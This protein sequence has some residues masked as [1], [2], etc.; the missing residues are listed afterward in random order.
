VNNRNCTNYIIVR[1]VG[2]SW[3]HLSL[4]MEKEFIRRKYWVVGMAQAIDHLPSK[5]EA[6]SSKSKTTKKRIK[7]REAG[8]LV[9][10]I[11]LKGFIEKQAF[12]IQLNSINR[13]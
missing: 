9:G 2:A 6:L 3:K 1:K 11:I 8:V 5:W 10:T 7:K 13:L 4:E 12:L